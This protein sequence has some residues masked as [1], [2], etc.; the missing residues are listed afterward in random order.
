MQIALKVLNFKKR[1]STLFIIPIVKELDFEGHSK[2]EGV[3][4]K[5][6]KCDVG[7]GG[8]VETKS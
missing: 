5:V 3:A 6:A 8:G 1:Y 4:R 2:E 7:W